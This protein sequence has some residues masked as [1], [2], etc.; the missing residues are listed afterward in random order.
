MGVVSSPLQ[1]KGGTVSS[2]DGV[3]PG[4][5]GV[6][7]TPDWLWLFLCCSDSWGG[8]VRGRDSR[9]GVPV[10]RACAKTIVNYY[11]KNKCAVTTSALVFIRRGSTFTPVFDRSHLCLVSTFILFC[12]QPTVCACVN[13]LLYFPVFFLDCMFIHCISAWCF[14]HS[15][16]NC[17][18]VFA[19][20]HCS[21]I[22]I[23]SSTALYMRNSIDKL[24]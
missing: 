3:E 20:F 9:A 16:L 4:W 7:E 8:L 12:S 6:L 10:S 11:N 24:Y 17:C 23:P 2:R 13:A 5:T 19:H 15:T 18:F 14:F 1:R 22:W 21:C